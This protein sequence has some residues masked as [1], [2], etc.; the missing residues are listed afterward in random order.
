MS[1]PASFMKCLADETRFLI[2]QLVANEQELCVCELVE[3]LGISQP[4]IS[5]H[6]AQLRTNEILAG[7]RRDQWVFYRLHPDLPDW[8][9]NVI[10][11]TR[12]PVK[13]ALKQLRKKLGK[14]DCRPA[15]D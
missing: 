1:T 2:T 4:N 15:R 10:R 5:R 12:K 11:E 3:A 13:P 8:A 7:R 14:M 6:L 9:L